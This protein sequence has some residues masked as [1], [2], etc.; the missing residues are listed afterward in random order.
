[1]DALVIGDY[2]LVKDTDVAAEMSRADVQ[3]AL[4]AA[5]ERD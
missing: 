4:L 2:L 3:R 5:A 1:M